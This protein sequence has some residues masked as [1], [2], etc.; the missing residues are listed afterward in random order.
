MQQIHYKNLNMSKICIGNFSSCNGKYDQLNFRPICD[1]HI[2][3]VFSNRLCKYHWS[4]PECE[5]NTSFFKSWADSSGGNF[6]GSLHPQKREV[7]KDA[8]RQTQGKTIFAVPFC[9]I[10]VANNDIILVQPNKHKYF[11]QS[12]VAET[13]ENTGRLN[14]ADPRK[15][16]FVKSWITLTHLTVSCSTVWTTGKYYKGLCALE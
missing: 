16:S 15:G 5:R 2:T 4:L 9:S 7:G 1:R 13:R 8:L 14:L 6:P 10:I 12:R 11:S 3:L